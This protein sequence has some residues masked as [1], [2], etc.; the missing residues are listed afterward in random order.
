M[1]S[2]SK[3]GRIYCL[4]SS[5]TKKIYIGSTTQTLSEVFK[6]YKCNFESWKKGKKEYLSCFEMMKYNGCYIEL[7]K[8]F[9]YDDINEL[10]EEKGKFQKDFQEDIVNKNI[11]RTQEDTNERKK[12]NY[13][14]NKEELNK[15]QKKRY[16]ENK[17][18]RIEYGKEY[19]KIHKDELKEKNKKDYR[20]H[21]RQLKNYEIN[22]D[23]ILKKKRKEY[24]AHVAV[25]IIVEVISVIILKQKSI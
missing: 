5:Q 13:Q 16:Q 6:N 14:N 24:I 1:V 10:K 21:K 3:I 12:N 17:E 23:E 9:L 8:E 25:F 20:I 11:S 19:Y 7:L 22:R 18:D 2:N 4:K 15:K